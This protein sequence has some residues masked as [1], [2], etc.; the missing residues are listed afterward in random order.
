MNLL[1]DTCSA[2]LFLAIADGRCV[3]HLFYERMVKGHAEAIVPALATLLSNA[4]LHGDAS[5]DKI[6]VC[7]GP[8]SFTGLRV[9]LAVA[10]ARSALSGVPLVALNRLQCLAA[11]HAPHEGP[12]RIEID[13]RRGEHFVQ[14]FDDLCAPLAEPMT[15]ANASLGDLQTL[16]PQ[17]RV[18]GDVE[19][20]EMFAAGIAQLTHDQ[21]GISHQAVTPLYVRAP[22][23][24][25]QP[26]KLRTRQT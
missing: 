8:G 2:A 7:V 23:A 20:P 10:R 14:R 17:D 19:T 22:D 3:R 25:A 1:I 18:A 9:G 16:Y 4:G 26:A 24:K 21:P 15:V 12:I 5:F 11:S 13:A 6:G